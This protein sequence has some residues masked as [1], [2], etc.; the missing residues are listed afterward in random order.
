MKTENNTPP[1]RYQITS[2]ME[3]FSPASTQIKIWF[4]GSYR[5][6]NLHVSSGGLA[7]Q[8]RKADGEFYGFKIQGPLVKKE[9]SPV[10]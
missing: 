9:I 8:I 4:A 7:S 1:V 6:C 2:C 10:E 5:A 3:G